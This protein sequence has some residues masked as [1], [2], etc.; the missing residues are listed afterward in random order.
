MRELADQPPPISSNVSRDHVAA[1][2]ILGRIELRNLFFRYAES[3]PF[4]LEN[5]NLA[6]EPGEF[7][8]IMGPSGGGKTTLI[9]LMLGLIEPTHGEL[10][11]DGVPLTT[12]G[13][14]V[15]RESIAAVMQED[16]L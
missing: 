4:V 11:I 7:I 3:D 12:I 15:Y 6:I 2:P 16:Q 14:R 13:P 8:T 5:I 1:R 9:K 10:F